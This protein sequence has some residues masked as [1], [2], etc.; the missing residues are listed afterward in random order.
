MLS[1][2]NLFLW[3]EGKEGGNV[4]KVWVFYLWELELNSLVAQLVKC[5]P[6]MQETLVGFLGQVDTWSRDRLPT[7]WLLGGSDSKESTCNVGNLGLIPGLQSSLG[8]GNGYPTEHSCL[9]NPMNRGA[10]WATVHAIAKS[11]TRLSN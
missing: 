6:A 7:P 2:F 3:A 11:G 8:E 5:L 10:W 9:E 1:L 4:W